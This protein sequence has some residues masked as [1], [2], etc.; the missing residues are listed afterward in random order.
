VTQATQYDVPTLLEMA[1]A[2]PRGNRHDCPKCGARRTVTNTADCFFCH[3]CQWKGNNITLEKEL[4]VH[5]RLSRAEYQELRRKRDRA[6]D[7][8]LRLCAAVKTRRTD[9]LD[10][11]YALNRFEARARKAGPTIEAAW[12]GLGLTYADRPKVLSELVILENAIACDLVRFFLATEEIRKEKIGRV[13]SWGG[14]Y[15]D[16]RES[17]VEVNI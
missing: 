11:L 4:G 14:F 13:L 16:G 5:R 9:L 2:K 7:A 3:H 6:H 15:P 12:Q 1:G 10:W 17:F 8:A